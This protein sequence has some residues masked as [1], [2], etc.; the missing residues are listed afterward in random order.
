MRLKSI[1]STWVDI[2]QSYQDYVVK[3]WF[4]SR[5]DS[6]TLIEKTFQVQYLCEFASLARDG[7]GS[8]S[9]SRSFNHTK[10]VKMNEDVIKTS[11]GGGFGVGLKGNITEG[12]HSKSFGVV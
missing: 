8:K 7:G 5:I 10:M 1:R 11:H 9:Q 3:V 12:I 6:S 2:A 4:V